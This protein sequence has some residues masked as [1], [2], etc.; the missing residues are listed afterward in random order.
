MAGNKSIFD[1]EVI[2]EA[3]VA[4]KTLAEDMETSFT[5]ARTRV[6]QLTPDF[7]GPAGE[8]S[9]TFYEQLNTQART[10]HENFVSY[11]AAL[12]VSAEALGDSVTQV[13]GLFT[14]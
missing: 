7:E 2:R 3:S 14:R 9:R 5:T 13:A 12:G 11:A 10:F 4:L 1:P 8:A 6:E